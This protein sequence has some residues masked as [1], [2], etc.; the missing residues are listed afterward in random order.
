LGELDLLF[1]PYDERQRGADTL[2]DEE[3]MFHIACLS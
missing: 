2:S 3:A 1:C